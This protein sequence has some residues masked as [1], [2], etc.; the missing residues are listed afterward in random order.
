MPFLFKKQKA[1]TYAY[2]G[3]LCLCGKHR[4]D[5]HCITRVL[6]PVMHCMR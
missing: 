1:G 4:V 3:L 6:L 2:N 5:S